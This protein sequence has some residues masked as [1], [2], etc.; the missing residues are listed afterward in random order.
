ME[1]PLIDAAVIF[2]HGPK[3]GV[4]IQRNQSTSNANTAE[5]K[6]LIWCETC[7]IADCLGD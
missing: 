3:F 5:Y 2:S 4:I 7:S 1:D 6:E